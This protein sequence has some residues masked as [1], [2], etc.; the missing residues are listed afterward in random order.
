MALN[1]DLQMVEAKKLITNS[2]AAFPIQLECRSLRMNLQKMKTYRSDPQNPIADLVS[3]PFLSNTN[4]NAGPF[5][6]TQ[7][8]LQHSARRADAPKR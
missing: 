8:V 6:R 1:R 2:R 3:V 5:S 4:F 7:G